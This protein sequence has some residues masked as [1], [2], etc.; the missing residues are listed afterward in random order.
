MLTLLH[1]LLQAASMWF[2]VT[3]VCH[4][5]WYMYLYYWVIISHLYS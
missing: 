2:M 5:S 4:K 1:I 3:W